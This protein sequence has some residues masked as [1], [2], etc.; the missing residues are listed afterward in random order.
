MITNTT[1]CGRF[2]APLLAA[3]LCATAAPA[4]AQPQGRDAYQ[5]DMKGFIPPVMTMHRPQDE[6]DLGGGLK[7]V[8]LRPGNGTDVI[9]GTDIAFELNC[10][11]TKGELLYSSREPGNKPAGVKIPG[12]QMWPALEKAMMGMKRSEFRKI[13]M[14]KELMPEGGMGPLPGD[15]DI[16]LEV[17]LFAVAPPV[18]PIIAK[19][20][21]DGS[22]WM[23]LK[24]GEGEAFDENGF[25]TCHINVF[26]HLG[27]LMGSTSITRVPLQVAGDADRYWVRY[28][29]G[30]QPGGT[31]I[32]EFDEPEAYR[33]MRLQNAGLDAV[34]VN[35]KHRWRMMVD[36]LIVTPPI[37]MTEHDPTKEVDI[38]DGIRI[39]DLV[40]GD[41]E[42]YPPA[43]P[44][45]EEKKSWTPRLNFAS[46][47][48]DD[49]TLFDSSLKPGGQPIDYSPGLYPSVWQRGLVGMRKGGKRKMIVPPNI[50]KGQDFRQIPDD[51]G[52]IYELELLDWTPSLF[53]FTNEEGVLDIGTEQPA[54]IG[55]GT[56]ADQGGGK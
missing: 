48:A 19:R 31:R 25:A 54:D 43:T 7:Y 45:G 8:V 36:C 3:V 9:D 33:K 44:P 47:N 49:G 15:K 34:D 14:P 17:G 21:K 20:G 2:A 22:T 51:R 30:M 41:G 16:V 5:I 42:V 29:H 1:R 26:N 53:D 50:D 4:L 56:A 40:I 38:G 11:T 23:D 10:F 12:T 27:E 28:A 18:D 46:W 35:R 13:L 24:L 6:V 52:F 55:G 37:K 32:I 39:V